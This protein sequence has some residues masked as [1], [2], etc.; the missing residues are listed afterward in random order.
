MVF[1]R[2]QPGRLHDS[3][4]DK[5]QNG[6][7]GRRFRS[8]DPVAPQPRLADLAGPRRTPMGRAGRVGGVLVSA[9]VHLAI[10]FGLVLAI[11]RVAP[12][13]ETGAMTVALVPGPPIDGPPEPA[14]ATPPPP[15]PTPPR[16]LKRHAVKRPALA[17]AANDEEEEEDP[18]P[19]VMAGI[20]AGQLAGASTAGSGPPGRDCDMIQFL[21]AALRR[22]P[23]IQAAV[24]SA[25]TKAAPGSKAILLWNGAWI[26]SPGQSGL[27]L[28]G[29]REAIMAE[30]AFAPHKC[31]TDPVKGLVVLSLNDS[32]SARVALGTG[33]WGWSDLLHVRG[34][35]SAMAS[36]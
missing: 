25:H 5:L 2:V 4:T 9:A 32:G 34:V 31:R 13:Q 3:M 21:E 33:S 8:P 19:A 7:G 24:A 35:R 15:T 22:D 23:D 28:A 16:P 6:I 17:V 11:P 1:S 26:R 14:A 36:N 29:V 30:V 10:L 12:M 20:S 18:A 27:G